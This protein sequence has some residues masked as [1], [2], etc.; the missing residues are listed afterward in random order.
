MEKLYTVREAA[1]ALRVSYR[2]IQRYLRAKKL[3]GSKIGQWRF[4][5]SQLKKFLN[6]PEHKA[7]K[8]D[9]RKK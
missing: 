1:D 7:K 8:R 4:S 3:K 6:E 5:E 2:T 9:V